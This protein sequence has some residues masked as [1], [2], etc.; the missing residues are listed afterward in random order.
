MTLDYGGVLRRAWDLTWNNKILWLFGL[1]SAMMGGQFSGS[2]NNFNYRFD[3]PRDVVP[4][5]LRNLDETVILL[6][7]VGII[8]VIV[9]IAI[10]LAIL[11][12]FGRGGLIGGVRLADTQGRVSF[13]EAWAVGRRKFWTVLAIGLAV[14][15]LGLLL[16]GMSLISIFTLCLAP[17]ACIG[18]LLI[19]LLGVYAR[20]AQIVAVIDDV[21]VAEALPRAWRFIT[22]N[23]GALVIMGL[24]LVV[25]QGVIGFVLSLPFL[26]IAAPILISFA[27]YSNDAPLMGNAGLA[28][29]G[30][31]LVVYVPV[32]I[33]A[34]GIVESWVMAAWT[35]TYRRLTGPAP[36][37]LASAA[38]AA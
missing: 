7:V 9:V 32:L 36:A 1:L 4:T 11:A 37:P 34:G 19:A 25:L 15:V 10:V 26:A 38:P 27:G 2:G 16:A 3:S 12:V 14:W 30:L 31:C 23:L 6:I 17:L 13:G 20:L 21:G 8:A 24:I 33:V 28:L 18:F 5:Q 35:L 22:A 29:A